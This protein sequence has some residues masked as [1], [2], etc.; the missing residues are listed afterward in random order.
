[1]YVKLRK[2]EK[3]DKMEK[4][5]SNNSNNDIN[6]QNNQLWKLSR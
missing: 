3:N 2:E 5:I 6:L 1:M 4:Y